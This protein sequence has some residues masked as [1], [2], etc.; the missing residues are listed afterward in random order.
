[1]ESS[2]L[3]S[4]KL[5]RCGKL[6]QWQKVTRSCIIFNNKNKMNENLNTQFYLLHSTV[7][8]TLV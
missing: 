2:L 7:I 1:M 6:L 3:L 8:F 4:K 5:H